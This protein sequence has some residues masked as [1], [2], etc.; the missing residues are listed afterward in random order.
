MQAARLIL[1]A[2]VMASACGARSGLLDPRDGSS[3][4][5]AT[6]PDTARACSSAAD[7]DDGSPCTEEICTPAGYC[8]HRPLPMGSRRTYPIKGLISRGFVQGNQVHGIVR[9]DLGGALSELRLQRMTLDGPQGAGT[10]LARIDD[11]RAWDSSAAHTGSGVALVS[12]LNSGLELRFSSRPDV[13]ETIS[14][15]GIFVHLNWTGSHLLASTDLGYNCALAWADQDGHWISNKLDYTTGACGTSQI[16]STGLPPQGRP[17]GFSSKGEAVYFSIDAQGKLTRLSATLDKQ[18]VETFSFSSPGPKHYHSFVAALFGDRVGAQWVQTG[19]DW[20]SGSQVKM[21]VLSAADLRLAGAA[22]H[23]GVDVTYSMYMDTVHC[24]GRF[25]GVWYRYASSGPSEGWV[26]QMTRDGT[27]LGPPVS[28][29]QAA[30][31]AGIVEA[32][33]VPGGV[34]ILRYEEAIALSCPG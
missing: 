27:L 11:Y 26:W 22:P 2:L 6:T 24:E 30:S 14:P 16:G 19:D 25:V 33:C 23:S 3:N 29:G 13:V 9:E 21:A 28:L 34:I 32:H 12:G 1:P 5:P 17:A 4:H 31:E 18:R 7:C 15:G 8:D 20:R 10:F